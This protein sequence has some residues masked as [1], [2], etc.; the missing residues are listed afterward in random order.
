MIEWTA[1]TVAPV[2][3][4]TMTS[5]AAGD[6]VTGSGATEQ[7]TWAYTRSPEDVL[8]LVVFASLSLLLMAL[9]LW[10]DKSIVGVEQDLL[11]L[12]DF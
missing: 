2:N 6:D 11:E 8:R 1:C 9:T 12:L 3:R 5:I 4:P 10:A 7:A